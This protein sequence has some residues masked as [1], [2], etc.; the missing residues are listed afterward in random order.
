MAGIL[1]GYSCAW[2]WC[3]LHVTFDLVSVTVFSTSTC[4][5]YFSCH[6]D[7]WIVATDYYILST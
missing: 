3:D 2:P 6:R 4:K 5:T 7:I 1:V